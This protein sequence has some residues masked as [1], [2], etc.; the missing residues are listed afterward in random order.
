MTKFYIEDKDTQLQVAVKLQP[1]FDTHCLAIIL[2]NKETKYK[3]RVATITS[4][5]CLKLALLDFRASKELGLQL[6]G[7]DGINLYMHCY[8]EKHE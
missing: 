4:E 8:K 2:E 6:H 3:K 7:E 1:C 5:G